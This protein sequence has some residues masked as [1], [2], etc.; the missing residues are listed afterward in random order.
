MIRNHSRFQDPSP[1]SSSTFQIK[2]LVCMTE[3]KSKE[4]MSNNVSVFLC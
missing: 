4:H 1:I 3:N 2:E